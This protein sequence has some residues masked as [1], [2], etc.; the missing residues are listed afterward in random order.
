MRLRGSSGN[1][2][3]HIT[4]QPYGVGADPIIQGDGI[5]NVFLIGR[6]GGDV[7]ANYITI[8]ELVLTN[9]VD[10][11]ALFCD[12]SASYWH[13]IDLYI[14]TST[15]VGATV[16]PGIYVY[17]NS[18]HVEIHDCEI[19]NCQGEGIYI[20]RS[21]ADPQSDYTRRVIVR[22]C[23]LH[24]NYNEGIDLKGIST[25]CFVVDCDLED[26]AR[27]SGWDTAQFSIGGRYHRL[28][29]CVF[30]G[31]YGSN[32]Y[33]LSFFYTYSGTGC[34]YIRVDHCLFKHCGGAN[35]AAVKM[36]GD[37]N[38]L[39]NLT[40]ADGSG[41][42]LEIESNWWGTAQYVRNCIF[43][44]IDSGKRQ[45]YI[46]NN[47]PLA[48][49]DLDYNRYGDADPVWFYN[50]ADRTFAWVQAQGKEGNGTQTDPGFADVLEYNLAVGSP[51]I[52][53][54]EAAATVWDW[55]LEYGTGAP[56]GSVDMGWREYDWGLPHRVFDSDF[57]TLD[58][59]TGSN[60]VVISA[61]AAY[62]GANGGRLTVS[63]ASDYVYRDN[64]NS[65]DYLYT[66]LYFNADGLTMAG[67]DEFTL[68]E[69]QDN[70]GNVLG[71][72]ELSYDGA[73]KRVRAAILDDGDALH[74]TGY[75]NID[76]AWNQVELFWMRSVY[77]A[78][79]DWGE[80]ILYLNC[81]EVDT[82]TGIDNDDRTVDEIWAG[83]VSGVDGGTSGTLDMDLFTAD[84]VREIGGESG[85]PLPELPCDVDV[86]VI[87]TRTACPVGA[88]NQTIT[89]ANL[90]GLT[91]K[92]ALFI[93][94]GAT[95]D[96]AAHDDLNISYG[97]AT[98]AG[99]QWAMC[100]FSEHG[101]DTTDSRRRGAIDACVMFIDDA[102]NVDG[103]ANFLNFI[104][105]GCVIDWVNAPASAWLLTVVFFAGDDLNAEAVTFPLG[106]QDVEVNVNTV[107]FEPDLLLLG[108]IARLLN[109]VSGKHVHFSVGAAANKPGSPQY[110]YELRSTDDVDF[111]KVQARISD[112]YG[113]MQVN[114]VAGMDWGCEIGGWDANGFSAWARGGNS[115][116][117][118]GCLA[119]A[120]DGEVDFAVGSIT[121]PVANGNQAIAAP[122]FEPQFVMAGLTYMA[123]FDT[124]YE[125]AS[126]GAIGLSVFDQFS[127]AY[128]NAVADEDNQDVSDTQS[129]SDDQAVNF[130][131]HDGAAGYVA[132]L[133]SLD[134]N[135]WTWNF[136]A[137]VG[138]ADL[139]WYVAIGC[140]PLVPP[141]PPG[142]VEAA[143][144]Y[145]LATHT[146]SKGLTINVFNP[147]IDLTGPSY[148]P[149]GIL[150]GGYAAHI[151]ALRF[152]ISAWLGYDNASITIAGPVVEIEDWIERGLGRHIEIYNPALVKIWA[153]FANAITIGAGPLSQT[154]GPMMDIG[155]RVSVMYAPILDA[156]VDP[157]I[158]GSTQPTTIA[159]TAA[160][161]A[162]YGII[163][164]V[165]SG[166][167]TT[168]DDAERYRDTFAQEHAWPEAGET[169]APGGGN[170]PSVRLDC[171]GYGAFLNAY[172]YNTIVTGTT[173]ASAKIQAI[174]AA[175]PNG[176]F[177]AD[178]SRIDA[179]G[180]LVPAYENDNAYALSVL[181]GVV[182]LGDVNDDRWLFGIYDEQ[183]AEYNV[184]P[185]DVAYQH[186]L[187]DPAQRIE[188]PSSTL[189]YPWDVRPGRWLFI[190]D[191]LT[192]RAEPSVRRRDL[193]YVFIESMEYTAPFDLRINGHKIGKLSQVL[194]KQGLGGTGA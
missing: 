131:Q 62:H 17:G 134:A 189:V 52:N 158:V 106:N 136:T 109:D 11:G 47:F 14:H 51:C 185:T 49:Y 129:L 40:I 74:W 76:V 159:E 165:L 174:L 187:S 178:Y 73:N 194:A 149:A 42:G 25:S 140:E 117:D 170:E 103:E 80:I 32:R 123:A 93:A 141:V 132:T 182:A 75:H 193:R 188:T 38:Y 130:P 78:H 124:G 155:N 43:D 150:V 181:Q 12:N 154:L 127:T 56:V 139:W 143:V 104:A 116:D 148:T 96:G 18:H 85:P 120:F 164:K 89:T 160:S 36:R 69:V 53:D 22:D 67:G 126:A 45:V 82:V 66:R 83:V 7:A 35:G 133:V 57:D 138:A 27:G 5:T 175:D 113:V 10:T 97:A 186:R 41:H 157:P 72:I 191:W 24:D 94:V 16:A 71:Q 142:P 112:D 192:G 171:L 15:V 180:Y 68:T 33:G 81:H 77:S 70:A 166:S 1:F 95:A 65:L 172:V 30:E 161:Q 118:I 162:R 28:M 3:N 21:T 145:T 107:G 105:N 179:N 88:G 46:T 168:T 29:N 19:T 125:D 84:E 92:A 167:T 122:G 110:C 39:T 87:T 54:G 4:I 115:G 121:S 48:R 55:N 102:G 190:P 91:P 156:T 114:N 183:R 144:A 108:S 101:L 135:G 153:G 31:T 23:N 184:V 163:E 2:S 98:S 34:R 63:G 137:Q 151:S 26:N 13:I 147:K 9:W 44:N 6:Y 177:S 20:G 173:T 37:D 111:S 100:T 60:S 86:T 152:T 50:G 169:V 59:F 61:A 119:L 99:A 146:E 8:R 128:C 79:A 90:D 176:L 64:L 58:D